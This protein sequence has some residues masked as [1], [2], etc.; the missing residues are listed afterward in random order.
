M[1]YYIRQLWN[2]LIFMFIFYKILYTKQEISDKD[3]QL[4]IN[5]INTI[6]IFTIKFVQWTKRIIEVTSNSQRIISIISKLDVF[7]EN[8]KYHDISYT[9]SLYVKDFKEC[10]N[11]KY[12]LY[13]PF[14]SGS[15]GQVYIAKCKLTEKLVAIKCMHPNIQQQL[16]I[17]YTLCS[18]IVFLS[19]IPYIKMIRLPF[20]ILEFLD[21]L[22]MQLDYNQE[23]N[24]MKK[25][26]NLNNNEYI[27]IPKYIN[28]SKH[29]IIMS[30][31]DG[32]NVYEDCISKYHKKKCIMLLHL[33]IRY[34]ICIHGM[35]HADLHI[36]NWKISRSKVN[37]IHPII[38]YDYGYV[39]NVPVNFMCNFLHSLDVLDKENLVQLFLSKE[40]IIHTL[41]TTTQLFELQKYIYFMIFR[42]AKKSLKISDLINI[43]NALSHKVK[44]N[45]MFINFF[46]SYLLI[47][48]IF[49]NK[50]NNIDIYHNILD[51]YLDM[52]SFCKTYNIFEEYRL[53]LHTIYIRERY[54]T[55]L[56]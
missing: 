14:A 10:I 51:K 48:K 22:K 36:G 26:Y 41:C 16:Y 9:N 50:N 11:D 33:F 3:V 53:M 30:Y 32:I 52:I 20:D 56:K 21:N 45:P 23:V 8:C 4:L 7:F 27:I 6:G 13:H 35:M 42:I 47:G 15:I 40:C 29:F 43:A 25:F 39:I 44:L 24:N 19:K 54:N 17:P 2:I 1:F 55:S 5:S 28:H 46:V 37:N 38:I 31:E 34:N 12:I 18:L 49:N